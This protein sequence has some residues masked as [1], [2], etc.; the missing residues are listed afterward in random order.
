MERL[1]TDQPCSRNP[2]VGQDFGHV[3]EQ[4]GD[5]GW[6]RTL[7][8]TIL[9]YRNPQGSSRRGLR[10]ATIRRPEVKSG[11]P[12]EVPGNLPGCPELLAQSRASRNPRSRLF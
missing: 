8:A 4:S 9:R 12:R 2:A 1:E 7:A 5:R 10:G 3:R 11:P 6:S